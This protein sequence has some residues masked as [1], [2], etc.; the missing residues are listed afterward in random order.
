M[1]KP[2][3]DGYHAVTPYLICADAARA[4]AFYAAAFGAAERMRLGAPGGKVGHAEVTIGDCT[5]MLADEHPELGARAPRSFGGSP[6][7]LV[8]YVPDVDATVQRA[9]A[10]GATLQRAVED[11]FY[12]DRMGS[13]VDPD[14][15]IWHVA[16]HVEDMTADELRRRAELAAK[17]G[18]G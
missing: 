11:K 13:I 17:A 3:P 5:I 7:S 18:G 14:G 2:I 12:G 1:P 4:I 10:A 8:L 6:V 15:H 16:T 9:V